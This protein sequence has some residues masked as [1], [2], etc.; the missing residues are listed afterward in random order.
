MAK[1]NTQLGIL[2][3]DT[4]NLYPQRMRDLVVSSG[5][6]RSCV[7]L[8]KR[9][10]KGSGAQGDWWDAKVN[11]TG[12]TVDGLLDKHADDI[13]FHRGFALL[14]HYNGLLVPSQAFFVPFMFCRLGA[15]ENIGKIAMY[16]N[17]DRSK[18]TI[19][20]EDIRFYHRFN[21][22]PAV[23]SQQIAAAGGPSKYG[24]QILWV[25][26]DGDY[27]YPTAAYDSVIE[28]IYT[29][30]GIKVFRN[31]VVKRSFA[32]AAVLVTKGKFEGETEEEKQRKEKEFDDGIKEFQGP[33]NAGYIMH[34]QVQQ[35]EEIPE[36]LNFPTQDHSK[37]FSEVRES[38]KTDIIDAFNQPP[39]L[40]NMLVPGKL[41]TSNEILEAQDFYNAITS[42]ERQNLE[43]TYKRV[44]SAFAEPINASGDYTIIP[45]TI[46]ATS[47]AERKGVVE[48]ISNDKLTPQQKSIILQK[49]HGFEQAEADQLAGVQAATPPQA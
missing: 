43:R 49:Y 40:R 47:V 32:P 25:S 48:I 2:N 30:G 36:V 10:I 31:S 15:G 35:E 4:D 29:D 28:D 23:V 19:K 7:R 5:T 42:E 17:W 16:N 46:V 12:L 22:D 37:I 45:F 34:L 3:Y 20:K 44:F 1:E 8:Y 11:K 33:E 18:G 13:A 26:F 21:P 6:A 38:V 41:G 24:G 14:I 27:T 9:F 39:V